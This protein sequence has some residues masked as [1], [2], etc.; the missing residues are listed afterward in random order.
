MWNHYSYCEYFTGDVFYCQI[1][2]ANRLRGILLL[3]NKQLALNV[4]I[5]PNS[6]RKINQTDSLIPTH[7]ETLQNSTGQRQMGPNQLEFDCYAY[8]SDRL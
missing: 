4:Q 2:A 7:P 3:E 5:A 1:F 8:F 6:P